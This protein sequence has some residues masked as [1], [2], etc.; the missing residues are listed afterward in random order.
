[1][2]IKHP[3]YSPYMGAVKISAFNP[4]RCFCVLYCRKTAQKLLR[5]KPADDLSSLSYNSYHYPKLSHPSA[6]LTICRLSY[7]FAP[8]K[9][10]PIGIFP[11]L[12]HSASLPNCCTCKLLVVILIFAGSNVS[13][14]RRCLFRHPRPSC[15]TNINSL[16]SCA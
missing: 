15:H 10:N 9:F 1:V 12:L 8:K 7:A 14:E 11:L 16:V 4:E 3:A 5:L 13:K 2:Y 6:A